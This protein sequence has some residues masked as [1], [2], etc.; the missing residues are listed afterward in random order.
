MVKSLPGAVVEVSMV[1]VG[2]RFDMPVDD[3]GGVGMGR[4]MVEF[5]LMVF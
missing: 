1:G 3:W 4:D 5:M 2:G